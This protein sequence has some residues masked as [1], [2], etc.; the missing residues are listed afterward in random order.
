MVSAGHNSLG[1]GLR[2]IYLE[3]FIA[4][5]VTFCR[6]NVSELDTGLAHLRPIDSSLVM[7]DV[8]ATD[9][10]MRR[11]PF[12]RNPPAEIDGHRHA[13]RT[14]ENR[15]EKKKGQ[16]AHGDATRRSAIASQMEEAAKGEGRPRFR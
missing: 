1:C 11:G 15:R 6:F 8:D 2:E 10:I 16:T 13:Y 14:N 5:R 7:R 12:V 9:R 3:R 4:K